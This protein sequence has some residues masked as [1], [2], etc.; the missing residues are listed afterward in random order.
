MKS[1][2]GEDLPGLADLEGLASPGPDD[3]PGFRNPEGLAVVLP[4]PVNGSDLAISKRHRS[5]DN[6]LDS[7]RI[8]LKNRYNF[9]AYRK[10]FR[11]CSRSYIYDRIARDK[12]VLSFCSYVE[13][14]K[15]F[16]GMLSKTFQVSQT[17]KVWL[18]PARTTFRVFKTRKVFSFY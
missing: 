8:S 7:S 11:G 16:L 4:A 5:P 1:I 14:I 15:I 13:F 17:W 9:P 12:E 10:G 2:R 3:L 18:I 6:R